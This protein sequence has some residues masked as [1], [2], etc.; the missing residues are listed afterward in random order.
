MKVVGSSSHRWP[1]GSADLLFLGRLKTSV[2]GFPSKDIQLLASFYVMEFLHSICRIL[3]TSATALLDQACPSTPSA[4]THVSSIMSETAQG[5]ATVG[6]YGTP[7]AAA[8]STASPTNSVGPNRDH[9]CFSLSTWVLF[10]M[11]YMAREALLRS[12]ASPKSRRWLSEQQAEGSTP[13]LPRVRPKTAP[14]TQ[15][16]MDM[17]Q[18]EPVV[19]SPRSFMVQRRMAC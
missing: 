9:D 4:P 16:G 19:P 18:R 5:S 11:V 17:N 14:S 2:S 10:P 8:S 7:I 1:G 6:I 3:P 13:S 15:E 12:P